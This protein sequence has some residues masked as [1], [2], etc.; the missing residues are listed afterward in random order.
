MTCP[1]HRPWSSRGEPSS[2]EREQEQV[3]PSLFFYS[4][5]GLNGFCRSKR[6]NMNS[7]KDCGLL[8]LSNALLGLTFVLFVVTRTP[9]HAFVLLSPRTHSPTATSTRPD[10]GEHPC[11][12]H[13]SAFCTTRPPR[14]NWKS[15]NLD[16]LDEGEFR[17]MPLLRRPCIM[18]S[19]RAT[20]TPR[21][22]GRFSAEESP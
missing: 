8:P 5:L 13:Q 15:V 21:S 10:N 16:P 12:L 3:Q 4:C 2:S 14:V 11:Q 19:S 20:Q 6:T 18:K 1:P 22:R 17:C 9:T 7:R